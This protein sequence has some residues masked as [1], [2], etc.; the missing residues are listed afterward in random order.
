MHPPSWAQ[1]HLVSWA[2]FAILL[3]ACFPSY[4]SPCTFNNTHHHQK[5]KKEKNLLSLQFSRRAL[6]QTQSPIP[7]RWCIWN[8]RCYRRR[9]ASLCTSHRGPGGGASWDPRGASS[10][11]R[12]TSSACSSG[13]E[14]G[15]RR[16]RPGAGQG[17]PYPA[18]WSL[19]WQVMSST[20][21]GL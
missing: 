11:G 9:G 18:G 19:T 1:T 2:C 8:W 20:R 21:Y 14:G 12:C 17:V 16:G 15:G 4:T 3:F 10:R 13:G 7:L 6:N 5:K